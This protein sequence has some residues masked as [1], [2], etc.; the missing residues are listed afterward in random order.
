MQMPIRTAGFIIVS[1]ALSFI[2]VRDLP[3]Q[4]A[5]RNFSGTWVYDQK[6]SKARRSARKYR[7]DSELVIDHL[8]AELRLE[9]RN[10]SAPSVTD[11]KVF[12]TDGRGEKFWRL[13]LGQRVESESKT[14]WEGGELVRR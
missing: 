3:G 7:A 14:V 13:H 5:V 4:M 8:G 11:K 2:G 10:N 6:K 1:I 12:Y 9:S